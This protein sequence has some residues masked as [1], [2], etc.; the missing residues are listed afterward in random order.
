MINPR[1]R[2]LDGQVSLFGDGLDG[3]AKSSHSVIRRYDSIV[4]RRY[5]LRRNGPLDFDLSLHKHDN[6]NEV[7]SQF[8]KRTF[9]GRSPRDPS[10]GAIMI[11]LFLSMLPLHYDDKDR[12]CALLANALQLFVDLDRS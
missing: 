11:M 5:T 8:R 10:I 4:A 6:W 9:A 1:G 2:T 7:E 3:R 12:Q